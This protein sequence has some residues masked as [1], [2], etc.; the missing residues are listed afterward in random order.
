M[1]SDASA[2]RDSIGRA[3][4]VGAGGAPRGRKGASPSATPLPHVSQLALVMAVGRLAPTLLVFIRFTSFPVRV[5]RETSCAVKPRP[6]GLWFY[7][8]SAD[9]AGGR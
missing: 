6:H 5:H 2:S 3:A 7:A 4:T 1:R 9:F 8:A